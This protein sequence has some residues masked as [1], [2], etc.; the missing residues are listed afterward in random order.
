MLAAVLA[1]RDADGRLRAETI[2]GVWAGWDFGQKKQA[3]PWITALAYR[4]AFRIGSQS[5]S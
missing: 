2:S 3:S 4:A 1:K 5:A